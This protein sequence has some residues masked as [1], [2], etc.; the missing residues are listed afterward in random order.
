M[1]PKGGFIRGPIV[2]LHK[3]VMRDRQWKGGWVW[4]GGGAQNVKGQG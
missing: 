4:G 2:G 3:G 1:G